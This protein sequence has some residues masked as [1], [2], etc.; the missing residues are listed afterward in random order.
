[1]GLLA[2]RGLQILVKFGGAG[3]AACFGINV[4]SEGMTG[5]TWALLA[6]TIASKVFD[7]WSHKAQAAQTAPATVDKEEKT[8][9]K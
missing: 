7:F 9:G 3:L 1:M 8:S 4:G 6:G 2:S 5:T